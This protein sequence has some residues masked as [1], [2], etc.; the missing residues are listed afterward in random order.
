MLLLQPRFV[1]NIFRENEWKLPIC[2]IIFSFFSLSFLFCVSS[3]L[4]HWPYIKR[5]EKLK[6]SGDAL[7][8]E[9][10]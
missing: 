6:L 9:V 5:T 7:F 8:N 1:D 2:L 10:F 3:Y 4:Y